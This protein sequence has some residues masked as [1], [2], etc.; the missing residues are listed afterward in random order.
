[1][2]CAQLIKKC[3]QLLTELK[4]HFTRFEISRNIF[5]F[6]SEF[7]F[8]QAQSELTQFIVPVETGLDDELG[9]REASEVRGSDIVLLHQLSILLKE[10]LSRG[11]GFHRPR[12]REETVYR[13][14]Q[15][16]F[17]AQ[18]DGSNPAKRFSSKYRGDGIYHFGS[19]VPEADLCSDLLMF[20]GHDIVQTVESHMQRI[21]D[22]VEEFFPRHR[23]LGCLP[24]SF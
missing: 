22:A 16:P 15:L 23:Q 12:E 10:S 20:V 6:F 8:D 13:Q 24:E 18:K 11:T 4:N 1:M 7:F 2:T 14:P 9:A 3:C 21:R 19:A 17:R 5:P